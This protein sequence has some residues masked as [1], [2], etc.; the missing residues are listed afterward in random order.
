LLPLTPTGGEHNKGIMNGVDAVVIATGNDC[1]RHRSR[2]ARLC[3]RNGR[4]TSL[5]A[6]GRDAAGNLGG[7][8]DMPLA[9]GWSAAPRGPS[10]AKAALK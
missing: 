7:A 1:P 2:A 5:S 3:R 6:W 4:N 10:R 8:L 9:V